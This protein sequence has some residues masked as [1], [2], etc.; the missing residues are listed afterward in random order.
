MNQ[1]TSEPPYLPWFLDAPILNPKSDL[2]SLPPWFFLH[3]LQNLKIW[4]NKRANL[5]TSQNPDSNL[6]SLCFFTHSPKIEDMKQQTSEPPYLPGFWDTPLLTPDSN[7]T[8]LPPWFFS[9]ALQNVKIYE[10][11]NKRTSLTPWILRR[12][13][14]ESGFEPNLPTSLG[15]FTRYPIFEDLN[16]Q[17][18]QP[19]YLP[20]FWDTPLLNPGSNLTSLPPWVF[21]HALQKLKIWTNKRANLPTSQDFETNLC[22]NR[23]LA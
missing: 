18:S 21:S 12:T 2:T 19:P 15:F 22:W 13:Y 11:R 14:P 23:I 17:T 3:A 8:S 9:H 6:T 1:Q 10:P 16:Q 20:A 5:H 4:T 7:L